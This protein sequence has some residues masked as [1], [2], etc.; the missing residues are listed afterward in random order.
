VGADEQKIIDVCIK[1]GDPIPKS[2]SEAPMVDTSL[3]F[4]LE[5]FY[6][7]STE[8]SIGMAMGMIPW[9]ACVKYADEYNLLGWFREFFIRVI[10]QLD[11]EY[12]EII[13][14]EK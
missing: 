3:E 13:D 4:Y 12:R 14:K 9:S 2:I 10:L 6:I 1:R 11:I 8:R 5:A 7:L